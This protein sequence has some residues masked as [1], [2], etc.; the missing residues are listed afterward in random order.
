MPTTAILLSELLSFLRPGTSSHKRRPALLETF[1]D[2][3][4]IVTRRQLVNAVM[5]RDRSASIPQF[6]EKPENISNRHT[7]AQDASEV[8]GIPR[9]HR[10]KQDIAVLKL[11]LWPRRAGRQRVIPTSADLRHIDARMSHHA[12]LRGAVR[13][14]RAE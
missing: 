7:E 1:D 10:A 9:H 8:N 6:A 4:Q 11:S 2:W 5:Y 14:T 3:P 13:A 12:A